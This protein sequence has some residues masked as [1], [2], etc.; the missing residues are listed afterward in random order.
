MN[1]ATALGLGKGSSIWQR[2]SQLPSKW[3]QVVMYGTGWTVVHVHDPAP[4]RLLCPNVVP[5]DLDSCNI[6]SN[7]AVTVLM[8][9]C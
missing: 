5:W 7:S 8:T 2:C 9:S 4:E 1:K 3:T 6:H